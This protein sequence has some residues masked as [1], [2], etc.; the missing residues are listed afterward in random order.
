[1]LTNIG[2]CVGRNLTTHLKRSILAPLLSTQYYQQKKHKS[3][4]RMQ[5]ERLI[6]VD[7]EMT[8]L[9]I[10]K[11]L[12]MEIAVIVT[13]GDDT[14]SEV[15]RSESL[16]IQTEKTL[17][18]SMDEWCTQHH[19]DSGLT[20]ACVKSKLTMKAAEVEILT[21]LEKHT[22][23][24]KCPLAGNSVGQDRRF[25]DKCMPDLAEHLHYR[26]VDVSTVKELCKRWNP[27]IYSEMPSK[28]LSHRALDDIEDSIAELQ[29]YKKTLFVQPS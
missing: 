20:E 27:K 13:E 29:Y 25:L 18:D 16:I 1:M 12:I 23:K 22:Q 3:M 28:R 2:Q 8:G 26:T 5:K 4:T 6:W 15:C 10:D 24:G 19:G 21:L 7:C 11:D 14:L 17:L 9:N